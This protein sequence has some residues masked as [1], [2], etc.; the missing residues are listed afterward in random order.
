MVQVPRID[1]KHLLRTLEALPSWMVA[2]QTLRAVGLSIAIIKHFLG[3]EWFE[4]HMAPSENG[5]GGFLRI[6]PGSHPEAQVSAFR[7]VDFAEAIFNLQHIEGFGACLE[8]MRT[9]SIESTYAELDFG[10]WLY[11]NQINFRFVKPVGKKREDYDVE[12]NLDDGVRV[13]A[14]AKCK[15]EAN[16]FSEVSVTNTLQGA[17]KQFPPDRPSAIF[18]KIPSHWLEKKDHAIALEH[19]AKVF[20]LGTGRIVSVIFYSNHLQYRDG[21]LSHTHGFREVTNPNNRFDPR[22][23]WKL[24]RA[25]PAGGWNGMPR[26]FRRLVFF[27]NDGPD[28]QT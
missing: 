21:R 24:F 10:K 4:R 9:A 14:D 17:R 25:R 15:I 3:P 18:V 16:K 8:L 13:C 1:E 7:V 28:D 19:S 20:L 23:D 5:E 12:I 27:P 6:I 22:R 26:V 2:D 11:A